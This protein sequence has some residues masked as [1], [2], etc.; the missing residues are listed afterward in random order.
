MITKHYAT[1]EQ[2]FIYPSL[3]AIYALKHVCTLETCYSC[4]KSSAIWFI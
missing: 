2:C 1:N 4:Y 3:H